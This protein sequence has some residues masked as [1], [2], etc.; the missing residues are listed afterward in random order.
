[1]LIVI[2]RVYVNQT[3]RFGGVNNQVGFTLIL[4]IMLPN[5]VN[6]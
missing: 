4:A 5:V 3:E 2:F 1:M 6:L